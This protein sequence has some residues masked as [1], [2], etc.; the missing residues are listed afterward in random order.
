MSST[1]I[2]RFAAPFGL[3]NGIVVAL[4]RAAEEEPASN[5]AVLV[6]DEDEDVAVVVEDFW[7]R[8]GRGRG[9]GR[10]VILAAC[11]RELNRRGKIGDH[12][13]QPR[14]S[15]LE[16]LFGEVPSIEPDTIDAGSPLIA[17]LNYGNSN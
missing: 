2:V 14:A 16:V 17:V 9:R 6:V 8:R 7:T 4:E 15:S 3:D 10:S 13:D 1:T 11:W 12:H 5:E